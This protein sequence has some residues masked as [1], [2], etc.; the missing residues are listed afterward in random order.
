MKKIGAFISPHGY[1]HATRT[2]AVLEA[3]QK[4]KPDLQIEIFT[5]V[6]EHLFGQSLRN[7]SCHRV[8]SDIGLAQTDAMH[9]DIVE[10]VAK[11][12]EFL[13]FDP[14][15]IDEISTKLKGCGC[16]LCDISPLGIVAAKAAGIPS[17]LIE[18]FTWDWIYS[19]FPGHRPELLQHAKSLAQIYSR[20]SYRIQAEPVCRPLESADMNC[21]PIFRRM[22]ECPD[23]VKR[24]LGTGARSLVL[25][26]MG[27]VHYSLY[28][29]KLFEPFPDCYFVLAGQQK[30]EKYLD[31][32]TAL[33][34]DSIYYHPDL[35]GAADLV[36]CKSGYSTVA[37]CLQTGTRIGCIERNGF[38]ESAILSRFVETRLQG[39]LL[40]ED[41]FSA[42]S[43]KS[44]LPEMLTTAKPQRAEINGADQAA[45]FILRI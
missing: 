16:A 22:R 36:I 5:T 9:C 43:W 41:I 45:D 40:S 37:E 2:I 8:V 30:T 27:G 20:A 1:G 19:H 12:D 15:L 33:S 26:S 11:L 25:V 34:H 29:K 6:P 23:T 17:V 28:K 38:A 35:I 13:L 10:T 3:L 31:N 7:F 39:T 18:N 14:H 44:L 21:S 32:C 4:C 42:A 24:S